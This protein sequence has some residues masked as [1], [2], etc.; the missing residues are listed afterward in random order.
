MVDRWQPGGGFKTVSG[1]DGM[2]QENLQFH[3]EFEPASFNQNIYQL[4]KKS[5]C[6]FYSDFGLVWFFLWFFPIQLVTEKLC[7]VI[8]ICHVHVFTF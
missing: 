4:Y 6:S 2:A 8:D 7:H 5:E 3:Q 1:Q